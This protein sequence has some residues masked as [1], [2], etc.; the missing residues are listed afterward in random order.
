[1]YFRKH[2]YM[3]YIFFFFLV[4]WYG[5]QDLSSLT[6]GQTL[7]W[8]HRVLTT[9]PPGMSV[10]F[11]FISIYV[12][13]FWLCWVFIAARRPSLFATSS[14]YS[15]LHCGGFSCC[16]AQALGAQALVTVA[17]G[18]RS[19]GSQ[20]QWLWC[21]ALVAAWHVGSSQTRD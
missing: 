17:R 16:R 2:C 19:C 11:F 3:Y 21:M 6:K 12:F 13:Y 4:V 14:G 18:L 5:M 8:D 1:M 15:S 20:A 7:N 9:G 10:F